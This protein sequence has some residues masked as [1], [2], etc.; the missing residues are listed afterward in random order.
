MKKKFRV[1]GMHC[2]S[3]EVLLEKELKDMA[4]VNNCKASHSKNLLKI[5]CDENVEDED[6]EKIIRSCGYALAGDEKKSEKFIN[7]KNTGSDFFQIGVIFFAVLIFVMIISNF[8]IA[9][10]FPNVSDSVGLV[11]AFSLG[12][13]ASLSTCLALT[14]G[15]IM[16]FSSEY[17]IAKNK[18]ISFYERAIPQV[19]F[20]A[21]RIIGFGLLGGLLGE[22]GSAFKYSVSF[23][24][25]LTIFVAIVMF[26]IG[27]HILNIVPNITS[28]GFH[29][30]KKMSEKIHTIQNKDHYFMPAILGVLT[31]FLPC[32]FTQSMQLVAVASGSFI[33]GSL[34][35]IFF[36]LG[37]MPVLFSVGLG[38]SFV[39]EN[40]FKFLKKIVGVVIIFFA[41]YSLNS[42]LVLGGANFTLKF[43]QLPAEQKI[44]N[45]EI[46][47]QASKNKLD[48]QNAIKTAKKKNNKESKIVI[49][50]GKKIQ[51]IRMDIEY[52][53]KQTEFILKKDI[54]VYWEINAIKTTGCTDE[55]IIPRLKVTSGKLKKGIN[56]IKFTPTK[57]GTLPFS[58]WMGMQSG[59]FVIK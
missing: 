45:Q 34:V 17:E 59:R 31:F 10:F 40:R 20:H 42:G 19:Y 54:P 44:S 5:D 36:A 25:Y 28:L 41:M 3:C 6:I 26:Y 27:L 56:I 23:T 24:G 1:E 46:D 21:G 49:K 47:N 33:S 9:R 37:T 16:S 55:V 22:V 2:V 52:S 29:L 4:G 50:D 8:E 53:F 48:E 39:Q 43:W 32:G 11:V 12:I 51:I 30:P 15:I 57:T 38:S 13:I 14:G 58:C 18:K 35:M 7:K